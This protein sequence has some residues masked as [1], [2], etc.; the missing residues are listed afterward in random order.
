MILKL[1]LVQTVTQYIFFY[2]GVAHASGV[3]SS[4]IVSA[5]VFS[6]S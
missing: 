3:K 2:I 1:G 6:P 4:I 5:N